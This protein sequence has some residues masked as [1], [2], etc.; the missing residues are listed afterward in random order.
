MALGI[1]PERFSTL[2]NLT[3]KRGSSASLANVAHALQNNVRRS[4]I[5]KPSKAAKDPLK[6]IDEVL[7]F[8]GEN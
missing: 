5:I 7:E 1:S 6:F 4:M 2:L 3:N 8:N